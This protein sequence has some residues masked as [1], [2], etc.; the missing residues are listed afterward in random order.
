MLKEM[1][2]KVGVVGIVA[3]IVAFICMYIALRIYGES[4]ISLKANEQNMLALNSRIE[5][6]KLDSTTAYRRIA[7]VEDLN[8]NLKNENGD[9]YKL[10]K[11]KD[12]KIYSQTETIIRLKAIVDSGKGTIDSGK[13]IPSNL[14][15]TKLTFHKDNKFYKYD[16]EVWLFNPPAHFLYETFTPFKQTTYVS[17]NKEG[18][19]SGYTVFDPPWIKDYLDITNF[20]VKLDKDEYG[21]I[22][23]EV[24]RFKLDILL[25]AGAHITDRLGAHFGGGILI[26]NTHEVYYSKG[27]GDSFHYI[28]YSYKFSLFK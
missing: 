5:K 16:L 23:E 9:L 15:G 4:V 12:E 2:S 11:S 28:N 20:E 18:I 26:N 1:F 14:L 21:R 22:E 27:I 25:G 19:W 8:A 6:Y 13:V 24:N 7:F 3:I 10:L 17:R